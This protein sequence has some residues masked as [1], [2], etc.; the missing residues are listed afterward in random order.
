MN[1]IVTILILVFFMAD[2]ASA[3]FWKRK[4]DKEE[5]TTYS[6]MLDTVTIT[7]RNMNNFNYNR[8]QY[9]VKKVYPLADTAIQLLTQIEQVTNSMDKNRD[10]KNYKKDL[11]DELKEKFEDRLKNMS[12]TEGYVLIEIIERNTGEALYDILKDVKSGTTAF[13]WHN[14]SRMYGYDLKEGYSA[15]NNPMLETLIA[16]YEMKHPKIIQ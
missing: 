4:K 7:A 5:D 13:W 1:K 16:E 12:R 11:E 2:T 9:I 14:L 6:F 10:K 3:Q 8:Y 15:S